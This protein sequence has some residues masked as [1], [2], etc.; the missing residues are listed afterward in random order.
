MLQPVTLSV[1]ASH[2]PVAGRNLSIKPAEDLH[3]RAAKN[4]PDDPYLQAEWVRAV[5]VVRSTK[6]GWLIESLPHVRQ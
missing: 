6:G 3:A 4:Y 2:I 1:I 5:G